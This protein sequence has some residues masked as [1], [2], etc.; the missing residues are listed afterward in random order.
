[1]PSLTRR[2]EEATPSWPEELT[3]TGVP[4]TVVPLMPAMKVAVCVLPMRMVFASA[5]TPELPISMLLLSAKM[6]AEPALEPTA[7]LLLPMDTFLSAPSPK[8]ELDAPVV[9]VKRALKPKALLGVP[10]LLPWRAPSPKAVLLLAVLA[11]RALEPK[12]AL[13]KPEAL[14]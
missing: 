7:M 2:E 4:V 11:K 6:K 8:A 12:A 9:L 3:R 5:L 14:F 10:V 1:M 13:C